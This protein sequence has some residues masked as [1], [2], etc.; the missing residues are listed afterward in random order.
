[1]EI[2]WIESSVGLLLTCQMTTKGSAGLQC[3]VCVCRGVV[4]ADIQ[5]SAA[6]SLPAQ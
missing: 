2:F 5:Y 1:M 6:H 4:A 3:A